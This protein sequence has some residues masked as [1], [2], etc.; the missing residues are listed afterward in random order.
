MWCTNGQC[1]PQ[2]SVSHTP[3]TTHPYTH[4]DTHTHTQHTRTHTHTHRHSRTH[5]HTH[6]GDGCMGQCS[7]TTEG[8]LVYDL[9]GLME[10]RMCV[11]HVSACVCGSDLQ[12]ARV[13]CIRCRIQ[14]RVIR[15]AVKSV[16]I[17]SV[18]AHTIPVCV[19]DL[20]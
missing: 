5:A 1:V 17:L 6:S 4:T 18:F 12:R 11:C 9:T 2:G 15:I 10:T 20:C 16:F 14:H 13:C 3:S 7:L 19:T 8:G